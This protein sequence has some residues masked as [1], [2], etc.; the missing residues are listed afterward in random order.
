M[1]PLHISLSPVHEFLVCHHVE[2]Q[3]HVALLVDVLEKL[4]NG[5]GNPDALLIIGELGN[6]LKKGYIIL[7]CKK[8]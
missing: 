1:F 3:T 4:A 8:Q 2:T 7:G 5:N 6:L